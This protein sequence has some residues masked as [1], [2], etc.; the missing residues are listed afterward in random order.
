MGRLASATADISSVRSSDTTTYI[1]RLVDHDDKV[2]DAKL[3]DAYDLTSRA[4]AARFGVPYSACGCHQ[5]GVFAGADGPSIPSK[6]KFWAKD[7]ESKADKRVRLIETAIQRM[8]QGEKDA[9]H[10]S[11]HN[12]VAVLNL[13]ETDQQR[14]E[15]AYKQKIRDG[16]AEKLAVKAEV[17]AKARA[18]VALSR[19]KDHPDPFMYSPDMVGM[20]M[21]GGMGGSAY[22]NGRY[23]GGGINPY[24]GVAGAGG[25]IGIGVIGWGLYE[26]DPHCMDGQNMQRGA[27]VGCAC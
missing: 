16:K 3:G 14:A 12:L 11:V 7:K 17:D 13:K 18:E 8:E 20:G 23:R 24:W 27:L 2:S 15:R 10:P 5:H 1:G 21:Y 22:N 6:L 9:S 19:K 26:E 25:V 4:W